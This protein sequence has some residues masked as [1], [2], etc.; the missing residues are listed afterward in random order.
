MTRRRQEENTK[1]SED[2]GIMLFSEIVKKIIFNLIK[3]LILN[4][5]RVFLKKHL[6]GP[7]VYWNNKDNH[8]FSLS[9]FYVYIIV[10]FSY[11]LL[12]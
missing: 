5:K 8:F 12:Q 4:K 3:K 9:S 6:F 7:T 10:L 1:T 2:V 11:Q